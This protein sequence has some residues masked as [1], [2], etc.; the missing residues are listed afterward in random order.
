LQE[1]VKKSLNQ[2]YRIKY[3]DTTGYCLPEE[4]GAKI[5]IQRKRKRIENVVYLVIVICVRM[6]PQTQL[7]GL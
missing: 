3:S 7:Q 2:N 4:Y 5:K 6:Q 1:L